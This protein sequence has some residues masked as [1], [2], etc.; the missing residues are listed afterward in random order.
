MTETTKRRKR[1]D[2]AEMPAEPEV[3]DRWLEI[4]A[5]FIHD[6]EN[7]IIFLVFLLGVIL[8]KPV[9]SALTIGSGGSG[10]GIYVLNNPS[11]AVTECLIMG[12]QA[13][14][15]GGGI[16]TENSSEQIAQMRTLYETEKKGFRRK[17]GCDRWSPA[18]YHRH[19]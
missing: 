12:N 10:G 16:Y 7:I 6:L 13:Y 4:F 17:R 2:L 19:Y 11:T 14:K 18:L 5:L 8:I 1:E 9:A 15:Q 3:I